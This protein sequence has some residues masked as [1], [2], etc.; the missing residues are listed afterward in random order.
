MPLA[1]SFTIP[2]EWKDVTREEA[3]RIQEVITQALADALVEAW[4][5][6][7]ASAEREAAALVEIELRKGIAAKAQREARGAARKL[8]RR[9]KAKK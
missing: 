6:Q 3:A 9:R 5:K 1:S 4:R 2:F 7:Q 8:R